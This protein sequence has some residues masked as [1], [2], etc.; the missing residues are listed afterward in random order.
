[1]RSP[2]SQFG[3]TCRRY[4]L[5]SVTGLK[6]ANAR[7][8]ESHD[9]TKLRAPSKLHQDEC[10]DHT[11]AFM[12]KTQRLCAFSR[13]ARGICAA[14]KG[15]HWQNLHTYCI[16]GLLERLVVPLHS[17]CSTGDVKPLAGTLSPARSA[18]LRTLSRRDPHRRAGRLGVLRQLRAG[19]ASP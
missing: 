18:P 6:A 15:R 14:L 4:S 5:V 16:L 19:A 10:L 8:A 12:Q 3:D 17:S 9:D 11:S 1:M 2:K 13:H 7:L